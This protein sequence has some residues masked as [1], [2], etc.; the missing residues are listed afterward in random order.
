MITKEYFETIYRDKYKFIY[1]G[2]RATLK[3]HIMNIIRSELRKFYL[4]NY[5]DKWIDTVKLPYDLKK[6][7]KYIIITGKHDFIHKF[8]SMGVKKTGWDFTEYFNLIDNI[9]IVENYKKYYG[10]LDPKERSLINFLESH[11]QAIWQVI[12]YFQ[13]IGIDINFSY[14]TKVQFL[15]HI[16]EL[17]RKYSSGIFDQKG[18]LF[19]KM[20]KE[21]IITKSLGKS[22]VEKVINDLKSKEYEFVTTDSGDLLDIEKGIDLIFINPPDITGKTMQIKTIRNDGVIWGMENHKIIVHCSVRA[23]KSY[24]DDVDYFAFSNNDNVYYFFNQEVDKK[25]DGK[26]YLFKKDSYT[27]DLIHIK[28]SI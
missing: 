9:D 22:S 15:D 19:P 12:D 23:I 18:N 7:F 14:N 4:N 5:P 3:W 11:E 24:S 13:K 1:N 2:E 27:E 26:G 10:N 8:K 6:L 16:K 20:I 25:S 28:K 21:I 17:F